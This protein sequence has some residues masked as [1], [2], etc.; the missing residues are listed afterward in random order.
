M[1]LVDVSSGCTPIE[2]AAIYLWHCSA[3]G[4]YSLYSSGATTESWLRG[5]QVTDSNGEVTFTTIW[6][7]CY[8]GRWPHLHFEV[9]EDGLTSS[10]TG[11][12]ATLISQ[13]AMPAAANVA[14]YATDEYS[15]SV[16]PYSRVS[17]D[18]DGIFS[19]NTAAQIAQMTAS[20]TGDVSSGYT[21]TVVVGI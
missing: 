4:L 6:P 19:D 15:S 3:D 1:Q 10:S 16:S 5:V 7:G 11:R 18:T 9:F 8:S 14:V 21:G 17:L 2:G 20:V 13:I 12:T